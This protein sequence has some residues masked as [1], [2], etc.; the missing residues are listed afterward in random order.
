[1]GLVDDVDFNSG[2][3]LSVG[4]NADCDSDAGTGAEAACCKG[5]AAVDASETKGLSPW[6]LMDPSA[7]DEPL[8]RW[9]TTTFVGSP[10]L[11]D[12]MPQ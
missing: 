4:L 5:N 9:R 12:F 1:L 8:G 10:N 3:R 6:H 2:E 11:R 7:T